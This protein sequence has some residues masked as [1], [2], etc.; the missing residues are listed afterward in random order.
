[1][2]TKRKYSTEFKQGAVQ[3][4]SSPGANKSQ[5]ARNR[6]INNG[7]L[8]RWCR[9]FDSGGKEAFKGSGKARDEEMA[10]LKRELARVRKERDFLK[11]AAAFFAR[12]LK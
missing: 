2:Q 9:E 11:D 4:A 1:M 3:L 12:E 5:A 6:G 7:V 10:A 8:A